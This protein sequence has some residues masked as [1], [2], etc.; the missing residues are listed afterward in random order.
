M[1]LSIGTLNEKN[2][3]KFKAKWFKIY[4]SNYFSNGAIVSSEIHGII[5]A[6]C[7]LSGSLFTAPNSVYSI[8]NYL[9]IFSTLGM[10]DLMLNFINPRVLDDCSFHPCVRYNKF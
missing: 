4:I 5:Q 2:I 6:N 1:R 3:V 9:T 7:R 10:P 8:I